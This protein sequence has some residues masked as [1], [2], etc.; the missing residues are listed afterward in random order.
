MA[1]GDD[2]FDHLAGIVRSPAPHGLPDGDYPKPKIWFPGR[3]DSTSETLL[4]ETKAAHEGRRARALAHLAATHPRDRV[5]PLVGEALKAEGPLGVA[6]LEALG[7]IGDASCEAAAIA[8][9]FSSIHAVR[10][11][12]FAALLEIGTAAAIPALRSAVERANA[13]DFLSRW[14]VDDAVSR[15]QARLLGAAAGQVVL[16]ENN[17]SGAAGRVSLAADGLAGTVALA[18]GEKE[19]SG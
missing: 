3:D 18:P 1:L 16:S 6:A 13:I 5:F 9:L 12:A 10:S 17:G 2:G 11:A 8:A 7:K 19:K 4:L 14:M 15:I